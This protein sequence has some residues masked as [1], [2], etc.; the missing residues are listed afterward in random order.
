MKLYSPSGKEIIDLKQWAECVRREH[1]KEGRSAYSVADF[2]L[3]HS[4]S[5]LLEERISF[6]LSQP[7]ELERGTPEFRASFDRYRGN[8]SNLDLGIWGR[9]GTKSSLFVGLEAKVDEPFGSGTVCQ[10]HRSA[11]KERIKNPRS[12][13]VA[14]IEGLLSNYFSDES[15]PCASKFSQVGYQ[16]LTGTAGTAAMQADISVFYVLVF[17]THLYDENKGRENLVDFESFIQAADG[18]ALLQ[19]GEDFQAHKIQVAGKPLVCIY[20]RRQMPDTA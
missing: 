17:K 7:V 1:W 9:V 14:R 4:G 2:M 6:V 5:K 11:V 20:D 8:P 18:K 19:Q 13:A 3:N 10:R 12:N 15:D 16:L